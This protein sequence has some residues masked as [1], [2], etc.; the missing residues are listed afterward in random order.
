MPDLTPERM[1]HVAGILKEQLPDC[2]FVIVV[3]KWNTNHV[4]LATN[5]VNES[6]AEMCNGA[7]ERLIAGERP[8]ST[9]IGHA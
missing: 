2:G 4:R 7:A 1:T 6:A 8:I 9:E 3:G 5:V